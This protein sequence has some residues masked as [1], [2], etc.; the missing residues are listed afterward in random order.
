MP[1]LTKEEAQVAL[2]QFDP[3]EIKRHLANS[4][5]ILWA[6]EY[7]RTERGTRLE[8]VDRPYLIDIYRDF[9]NRICCKKGSQIGFTQTAVGKCLYL[10][11]TRDVTMIYTMPTARDVQEFSQARFTPIIR[12]SS[13]LE[14]RGLDIDNVGIKRIGNSTIYFKGTFAEKQGISVPSDLNIHDELDFSKDDVKS[15]FESRLSVSSMAWQWDFSTPTISKFGIDREWRNSDK[16]QWVVK[17]TACNKYQNISYF[18][19]VIFSKRR[20]VKGNRFSGYYYGCKMC[21]TPFDIRTGQWIATATSKLDMHGYHIPQTICGVIHP[22]TLVRKHEEAIEKGK[23]RIF[24][25]FE[26]GLTYEA[27]TKSLTSKLIKDRVTVGT[28]NQGK[29]F[30]G[31]DQGDVIH[32]EITKVTDHRRVVQVLRLTSDDVFDELG[33]IIDAYKPSVVVLDAQPNHDSAKK[34]QKKYPQ[35]VLA[36]Y[37]LEKTHTL[38]PKDWETDITK[39]GLVTLP[40][41]QLLDATAAQWTSGGVTIEHYVGKEV[42]EQFANQMSN[43]K[44]DIIDNERTGISEAKWLKVGEDHFR[45]ADAYNY[46]ATLIG[47]RKKADFLVE[48]DLEGA[49]MYPGDSNTFNEDEIW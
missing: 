18:R 24:Y 23:E 32:V 49:S 46:V 20:V 31:A 28:T 39:K 43:M 29:I 7:L 47:S 21:S 41:T 35:I 48:G 22:G 38:E 11:D 3:D 44:R 26:L 8:F 27:G 4:D 10:G 25:N 33:R 45:H 1:T 15:V 14:A 2:Q 34:L 12:A 17:C 37:G 30:I 13:Y 5:P 6:H 16:R 9:H 40:R 42:I 19:N 36:Y